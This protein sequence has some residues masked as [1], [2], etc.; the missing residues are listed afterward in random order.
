M[1]TSSGQLFASTLEA[2]PNQWTDENGSA[3]GEKLVTHEWG[4]TGT[5]RGMG[6]FARRETVPKHPL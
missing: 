3:A 1:R 6:P 5:V 2:R 4:F